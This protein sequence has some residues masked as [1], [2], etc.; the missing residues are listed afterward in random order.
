MDDPT[1]LRAVAEGAA[2]TITPPNVERSTRNTVKRLPA[3][4]PATLGVAASA[5]AASAGA[6]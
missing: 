5:G 2:G 4:V 6:A 1:A 3:L